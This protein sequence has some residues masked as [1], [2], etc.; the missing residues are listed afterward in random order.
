MVGEVG[1]DGL[2]EEVES[3]L[4]ALAAGYQNGQQGLD[5]GAVGVALGAEAELFPDDGM[6]N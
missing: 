2:G 1:G 6:A 3:V 5:E 4:F